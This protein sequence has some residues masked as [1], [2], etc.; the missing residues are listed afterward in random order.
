M[1]NFGIITRKYI[2]KSFKECSCLQLIYNIFK[3][4]GIELQTEYKGHDINNYMSFWEKDPENAVKDMIELFKSFGKEAD[5]RFLKKG[6]I[7]IV[8]YR[9]VTFPSIYT[10][11]STVIV[12]TIENGI[13][14]LP[15]GKKFKPIMARRLF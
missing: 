5:I 6:D 13:I 1:K 3:D 14:L 12:A 10:G 15:I 7:V 11:D 4:Y 9:E 8:N 2:G